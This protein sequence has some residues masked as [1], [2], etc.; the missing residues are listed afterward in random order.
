MKT[1]FAVL[2]L[3]AAS[4]EANVASE[5]EHISRE[6]NSELRAGNWN[7]FL[8]YHWAKRQSNNA[9]SPEER[10]YA[11][12]LLERARRG[13]EEFGASSK[14]VSVSLPR[15]IC[16][17]ESDTVSVF[18][19]SLELEVAKD[20]TSATLPLELVYVFDAGGWLVF[21]NDETLESN[22]YSA[23]LARWQPRPQAPAVRTN[24]CL[25]RLRL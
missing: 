1:F 4:A 23:K 12:D 5:R 8:K 14:V 9:E 3:L 10:R 22:L 24:E 13:G 7:V 17:F 21:L 20:K 18:L 19:E 25:A 15:T 6:I 16:S 2:L 11:Q